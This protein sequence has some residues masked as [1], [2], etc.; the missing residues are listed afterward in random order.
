[1]SGNIL[2]LSNVNIKDERA[3]LWRSEPDQSCARIISKDDV[4]IQSDLQKLSLLSPL[5]SEFVNNLGIPAALQHL[6]DVCIILPD[7][8]ADIIGTAVQIMQG[9][10]AQATCEDLDSLE[11]LFKTLMLDIKLEVDF[12]E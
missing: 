12:V 5:M 10:S 4:N 3:E 2:K 1:M 7:F 9:G 6:R 8:T 11:Q